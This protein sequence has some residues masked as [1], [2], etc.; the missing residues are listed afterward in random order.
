[1]RGG[2]YIAVCICIYKDI[3]LKAHLFSVLKINHLAESA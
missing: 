1:M 2:G 3:G